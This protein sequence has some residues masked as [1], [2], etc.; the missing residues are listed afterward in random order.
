MLTAMVTLRLGSGWSDRRI[1]RPVANAVLR[2]VVDTWSRSSTPSWPSRSGGLQ[3]TCMDP[4]ILLKSED[5]RITS[6]LPGVPRPCQ[7]ERDE[8]AIA[9]WRREQ[10]L[11]I[12]EQFQVWLGYYWCIARHD[13]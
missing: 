7:A 12:L 9:H 3:W 5:D 4:D 13:M 8:A 1:E 6:L 11:V 10:W 2:T